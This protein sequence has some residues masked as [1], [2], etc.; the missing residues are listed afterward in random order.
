MISIILNQI[1]IFSFMLTSIVILFI[2]TDPNNP[3]F[4]KLVSSGRLSYQINSIFRWVILSFMLLFA[5]LIEAI[6]IY[7]YRRW[8]NHQ[9]DRKFMIF[10]YSSIICIAST[11]LFSFVLGPVSSIKYFEFMYGRQPSGLL[12][13]GV[14]YYLLPRVLK[15][16]VKTP[17]YILLY[18][19]VLLVVIP[20]VKHIKN[21]ARNTYKFEGKRST[22]K[23]NKSK[24][25]IFNSISNKKMELQEIDFNFKLLPSIKNREDKERSNEDLCDLKGL[26]KLV[27]LR[28]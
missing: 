23:T 17:L 10:L 8:K 27:I 7:Q 2:Y 11:I 20:M 12:K 4:I 6:T 1:F 16:C 21:I 19:S 18:F 25:E 14:I 26:K 3:L 15:E 28:E 24:E 9:N 22:L 5:I 13:Y